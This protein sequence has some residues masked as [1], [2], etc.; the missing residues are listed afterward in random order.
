MIDL[1]SRRYGNHGPKLKRPTMP[2]G[3]GD[4]ALIAQ[5]IV[6][7]IATAS[8]AKPR[9][10]CWWGDEEVVEIEAAMRAVASANPK[11]LKIEDRRN[12]PTPAIELMRVDDF[13]QIATLYTTKR[14]NP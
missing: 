14:A 9:S 11:V 10:L 12:G 8:L 2:D 6:L 3:D 5:V 7:L 1:C 4:I 13:E